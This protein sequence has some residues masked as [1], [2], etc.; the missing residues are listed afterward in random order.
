MAQTNSKMQTVFRL[1]CLLL[2][3]A[4]LTLTLYKEISR[5]SDAYS[6]E[7]AA[8]ATYTRSDTLTGF[9]FRDEIAPDSINNGPVRYLVREGEALS[10]GTVLAEVFRDDTGTD[11]RERAAAIYAELEALQATLDAQTDWIDAYLTHYPALMQSIGAENYTNALA[12]AQALGTVLGGKVCEKTQGADALRRRI[13]ALYAELSEMVKHTNDPAPVPAAMDGTF[14]HTADGYEHVFGTEI[15]KNLTP[16]G[17]TALL[18]APAERRESIGRLVSNGTWY[19]AVPASKALADTYTADTAY[20]M[21]LEGGSLSMILEKITLAENGEGALLLFRADARPAFL[22]LSRAQRVRIEKQ[23]VTG[24]SI[25]ACA[26]SA[27]GTVYVI[28][29]GVARLCPVSLLQTDGG[30]A[31]ILAEEREGALAA[32]ER[33]IVSAR[34]L[35]DGKVLK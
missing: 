6:F 11:K 20:T 5:S 8:L 28:R 2:V 7:V 30:C 31:L 34:Q 21:H 12:Q 4:L 32:G 19:L 25:P 27:Q 9:V 10:A 18:S 14:Y 26:L 35:F 15:A 29:D 13:D 17:L 22:S 24:L 23:A 1:L 33:V 16:E 3:L